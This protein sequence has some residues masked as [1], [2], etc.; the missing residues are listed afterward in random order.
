MQTNPSSQT[1][2]KSPFKSDTAVN[3]GLK[4]RLGSAETGGKVDSSSGTLADWQPCG[5]KTRAV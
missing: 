5:D 3:T 2:C 1:S 4:E